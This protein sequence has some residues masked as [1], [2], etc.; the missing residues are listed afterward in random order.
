[1]NLAVGSAVY[2]NDYYKRNTAEASRTS[3]QLSVGRG[4]LTQEIGRQQGRHF[5]AVS[6]F[7]DTVEISRQA[8]ELLRRS[9]EPVYEEQSE[10]LMLRERPPMEIL[11]QNRDTNGFSSFDVSIADDIIYAN[12]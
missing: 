11:Y 6:K 10:D 12:A 8:R 2:R 4:K 3:E 9:E 7:G 5:D 1:M